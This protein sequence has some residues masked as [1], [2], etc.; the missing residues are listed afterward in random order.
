MIIVVVGYLSIQ[1]KLIGCND[2]LKYG[3]AI[4]SWLRKRIDRSATRYEGKSKFKYLLPLD[5][6]IAE[7]MKPVPK[8]FSMRHK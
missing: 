7:R 1:L 8:R 4:L 3:S 2:P 6:E 5:D